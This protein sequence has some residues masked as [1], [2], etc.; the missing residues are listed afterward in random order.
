MDSSMVAVVSYV[1]VALALSTGILTPTM[2][3]VAKP[4]TQIFPSTSLAL[5]VSGLFS[6][7]LLT[8][9]ATILKAK[10]LRDLANTSLFPYAIPLATRLV[11]MFAFLLTVV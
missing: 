7:T 2:N 1:F 4:I 8:S 3:G 11:E 9:V 10:C 5:T 6:L